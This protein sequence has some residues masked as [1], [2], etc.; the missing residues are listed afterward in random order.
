M[1]KDDTH[2][3]RDTNGQFLPKLCTDPNCSGETVHD[4]RS[5]PWGEEPIWRCDGLTHLTDDGPLIACPRE[6]QAAA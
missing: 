6:H 4:T 3:P 2:T 5:T 1:V